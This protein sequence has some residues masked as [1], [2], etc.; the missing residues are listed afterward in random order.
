MNSIS[1]DAAVLLIDPKTPPNV[2]G[3]L[4]ACSIFG[5][6]ELRWTGKRVEDFRQVTRT[7]GT[8]F[9]NSPAK[10]RLPREERMK[11]YR[12]V[13]WGQI[14]D[15]NP[16][17]GFRARG[18]TPVAVEVRPNSEQLP[19]FMHPEKALYIFGP[20]DGSIPKGLLHEC[21]RFV[22]VPSRSCLNLAA[23]INVVLY[24]RTVK[25]QYTP[26]ERMVAV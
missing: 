6:N 19:L 12:N 24:D 8:A 9:P 21:E 13:D 23:C 14:P 3:A 5:V 15:E 4:R 2:G 1:T 26:S 20:E 10:W 11:E 22:I 16:I 17:D 25:E 18:F 7:A